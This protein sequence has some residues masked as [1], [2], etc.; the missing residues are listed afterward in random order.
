MNAAV[1]KLTTLLAIAFLSVSSLADVLVTKSGGRFEGQVVDTGDGYLLTKPNGGSM[2]FPKSMVARME[3][4]FSPAAHAAGPVPPRRASRPARPPGGADSASNMDPRA[5]SSKPGS[6]DR[7]MD[8]VATGIGVDADKATQ[9]AFSQAIEQVVGVLVDAETL[10]KNDQIVRDQV[11]TF[12]RGFIQKF[13]VVRQWQE[14]GL[15]YAR[16]K[17]SVETGRLLSFAKVM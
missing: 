8:V 14:G 13:Q 11:L 17:A 3:K 2:T 12:S 5:S 9:A 6:D 7:L 16:I 4:S 15:H 10:V 1:H